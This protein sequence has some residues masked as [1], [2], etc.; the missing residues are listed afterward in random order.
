MWE[1]GDALQLVLVLVHALAPSLLVVVVRCEPHD[2]W[3]VVALQVAAAALPQVAA[4]AL[5]QVAAAAL[6]QVA[7]VASQVAAA[8]VLALG[9]AV[10]FASAVGTLHISCPP[11]RR[12]LDG[13]EVSGGACCPQLSILPPLFCAKP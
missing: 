3:V 9:V 12:R 11:N 13:L 8:V 4:A 6:P 7:V 5:P 2:T 10:A 1:W